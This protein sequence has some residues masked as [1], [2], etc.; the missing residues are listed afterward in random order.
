MMRR[1]LVV[2]GDDLLRGLLADIFT[3]EGWDVRVEANSFNAFALLARWQA[4]LI[5]LGPSC[6]SASRLFQLAEMRLQEAAPSPVLVLSAVPGARIEP[7]AAAIVELLPMPFG[8][9]DLLAAAERAS[10]PMAAVS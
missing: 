2:A 9:R 7:W 5:V 6:P 8:L 1:T 3:E 4:D 10:R